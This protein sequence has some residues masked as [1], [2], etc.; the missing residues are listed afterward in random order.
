MRSFQ[1]YRISSIL[2]WRSKSLTA[3]GFAFLVSGLCFGQHTSAEVSMIN[4]NVEDGLPSDEVYQLNS[5]KEVP[6][7]KERKKELLNKL[8]L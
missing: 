6:D 4:F 7:S 8:N 1:S 3:L 5:D 2:W